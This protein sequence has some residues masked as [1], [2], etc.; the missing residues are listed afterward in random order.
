VAEVRRCSATP[1]GVVAS[2]WQT[3]WLQRAPARAPFL[4]QQT[5]ET[6]SWQ[7]RRSAYTS[8]S[9]PVD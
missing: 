5:L 2:G 3:N 8:R 1:E 9:P 6:T 7:L 4:P